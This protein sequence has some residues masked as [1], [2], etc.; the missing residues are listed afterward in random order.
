MRKGPWRPNSGDAPRSAPAA[1]TTPAR[2]DHGACR[3]RLEAEIV[4]VERRP[5][6]DRL[7]CV[8]AVRRSAAKVAG[9]RRVPIRTV[10]RAVQELDRVSDDVHRLALL[11]LGGFPLAPLQPAVQAHPAALARVTADALRRGAV[12][13]DVEVD[14]KSTR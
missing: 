12:D 2:A 9:A 1:A 14:R 6:S 7:P 10:A 13:A 3:G 5:H 8:L 11:L 4:L